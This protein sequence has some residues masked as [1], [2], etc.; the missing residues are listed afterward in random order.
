MLSH[1][2]GQRSSQ[3]STK[4]WATSFVNGFPYDVSWSMRCIGS[5]LLAA[6]CVMDKVGS[7]FASQYRPRQCQIWLWQKLCESNW[8]C[9][10]YG[11]AQS[12]NEREER[13]ETYIIDWAPLNASLCLELSRMYVVGTALHTTVHCTPLDLLADALILDTQ[14]PCSFLLALLCLVFTSKCIEFRQTKPPFS[15]FCLGMPSWFEPRKPW[16]LQVDALI[17]ESKASIFMYL[18]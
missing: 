16:Y 8:S 1:P 9:S 7:S 6:L 2:F 17:L 4:R 14:K 15:F 10:N 13:D 12:K 18:R 5:C 11:W 3:T